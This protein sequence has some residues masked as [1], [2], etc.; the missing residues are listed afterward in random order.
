MAYPISLRKEAFGVSGALFAFGK[1]GSHYP[2]IFSFKPPDQKLAY[3]TS[4]EY[5]CGLI[6]TTP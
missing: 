6:S 5:L 2:R 4:F 1:V 3:I